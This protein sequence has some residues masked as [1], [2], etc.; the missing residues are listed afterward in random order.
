MTPRITS[1]ASK[2]EAAAVAFVRPV[3]DSFAAAVVGSPPDPPL[4]HEQTVS[5]IESRGIGVV[6]VDTS[7]FGRADGG[8]TCLSVRARYGY[9][10][11][12]P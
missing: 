11:T 8:L 2:A 1:S 3:P 9:R 7:E 10:T 4:A 12:A 6:T 5:L